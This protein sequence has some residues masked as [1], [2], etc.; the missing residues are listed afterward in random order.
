MHDQHQHVLVGAEPHDPRPDHQIR[1]EVKRPPDLVGD[2][3]LQL[4]LPELHRPRRELEQGNLDSYMLPHDGNGLAP[5]R[6]ERRAQR[7]MSLDHEF[8][9]VS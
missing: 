3:P 2:D 1:L 4:L 9:R 8:K 5:G 7:G 6:N